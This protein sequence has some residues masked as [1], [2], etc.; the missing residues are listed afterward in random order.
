VGPLRVQGPLPPPP[1]LLYLFSKHVEAAPGFWP[2]SIAVCGYPHTPPP[3]HLP[4]HQPVSAGGPVGNGE[5]GATVL[6]VQAAGIACVSL[7]SM[8]AMG[9]LRRPGIMLRVLA[10]AMQAVN[11][12]AVLLTGV[13]VGAG[14]GWV[15][16]GALGS[17]TSHER[18]CA[19]P[20]AVQWCSRHQPCS[21]VVAHLCQCSVGVAGGC[22]DVSA[23]WRELRLQ[24]AANSGS[25][26]ACVAP[27]V[28]P[29]PWSSPGPSTVWDWQPFASWAASVG[30]GQPRPGEGETRGVGGSSGLVGIGGD[31]GP[32]SRAFVVPEVQFH[33]RGCESD[34][35]AQS[36]KA[37]GAVGGGFGGG[38]GGSDAGKAVG[39][40]AATT[41]KRGWDSESDSGSS[42]EGSPWGQAA[43]AARKRQVID[44]KRVDGSME[45]YKWILCVD[46]PVPHDWL[47]PQVGCA[48]AFTLLPFS[49]P[50]CMARFWC[51]VERIVC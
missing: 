25:E 23:A 40:H 18:P 13:C 27:P 36:A 31:G 41:L 46:D 14:G 22:E 21:Q 12:R 50:P 45:V 39:W 2:R 49:S 32:S 51:A 1:P 11:A 10:R 30:Y 43:A 44:V 28:A 6:P 35:G 17:R 24:Q 37:A 34:N 47:F 9:L 29:A 33:S 20:H 4:T 38:G 42:G 5:A 7:G 3:S 15:G 16:G 8:G 19:N 48:L 26:A